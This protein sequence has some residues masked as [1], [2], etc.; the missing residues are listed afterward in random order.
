[1]SMKY[2]PLYKIIF[3][4]I[5]RLFIMQVF[6]TRTYLVRTNQCFIHVNT[7]ELPITTTALSNAKWRTMSKKFQT[8]QAIIY[9]V[10]TSEALI[11][12]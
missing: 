5:N 11:I 1:M 4:F 8:P 6:T 9:I 3:I 10:Y 7:E 12:F 2:M